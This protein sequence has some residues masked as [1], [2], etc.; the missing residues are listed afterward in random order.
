MRV[1]D[2]LVRRDRNRASERNDG[3][4][5]VHG[6]HYENG[7]RQPLKQAATRQRCGL[8]LGRDGLRSAGPE[9]TRQSDGEG[10]VTSQ[11]DRSDGLIEMPFKLPSQL[12]QC[13]AAFVPG[14]LAALVDDRL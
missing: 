12:R 10:E 4:F 13:A 5:I 6:F 11:R 2:D 1:R 8:L 7:W 3:T 9:W 14:A